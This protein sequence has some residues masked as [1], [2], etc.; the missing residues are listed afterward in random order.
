MDDITEI[1]NDHLKYSLFVTVF[2]I[3]KVISI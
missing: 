1:K 2:N 3:L